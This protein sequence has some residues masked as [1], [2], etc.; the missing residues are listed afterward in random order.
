MLSYQANVN[1]PLT[2]PQPADVSS[3]SLL[4]SVREQEAQ[5]ERLARQLEVERE[6]VTHRSD[7]PGP[8]SPTSPN[9]SMNSVRQDETSYPWA[10]PFSSSSQPLPRL[11]NEESADTSKMNSNLLDSCL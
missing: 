1:S 10:S 6:S 9:L 8:F 11:D 5:F 2:S 3:A 7:K 4:K